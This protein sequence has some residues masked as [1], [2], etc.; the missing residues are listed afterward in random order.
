MSS[1]GSITRCLHLLKDGDG[2]AAQPLWEAYFVRLVRLARSHLQGLRG[3]TAADEEDVAL[4]A[5]E[6]FC[7]NAQNGVFPR[8]DDRDDLWQVLLVITVRKARSLARREKR[9]KR[10]AGRVV[11]FADLDERDVE[12][13]MAAE[14]TP[15]VALQLAEECQQLL[16]QLNDDSLRRVAICKLEGY[17]NREIA[18][19]MGCVETTVE[20]KLKSIR[21]LWANSDEPRP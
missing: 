1:E 8:L 9:L 14:P 18:A 7:R 16:E 4:S 20:R 21:R 17:T 3:K 12:A 19:R 11:T 6:S 10:G 2:D 13:V 5:F 15:E